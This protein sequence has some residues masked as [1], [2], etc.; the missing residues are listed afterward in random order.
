MAEATAGCAG[1]GCHAGTTGRATAVPTRGA[2]YEMAKQ[3]AAAAKKPAPPRTP[4]PKAPIKG[5]QLATAGSSC[6][7]TG[8]QTCS[9]GGRVGA[10]PQGAQA[11][12]SCTGSTTCRFVQGTYSSASD[13][14]RGNRAGGTAACAGRGGVGNGSCAT[15]AIAETDQTQALSGAAC[16]GS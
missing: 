6:T 11:A 15:M 3:A 1:P 8:T 13:V 10:T 9:V 2:L 4:G 7:A 5:G 12:A 14:F 16:Q